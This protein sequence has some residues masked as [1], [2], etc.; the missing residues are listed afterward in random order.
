LEYKILKNKVK[1]STSQSCTAPIK[2]TFYWW[3]SVENSKWSTIEASLK[4]A[5]LNNYEKATL[6]DWSPT[7]HVKPKSNVGAINYLKSS[8]IRK[9]PSTPT[10]I[11]PK[12]HPNPWTSLEHHPPH[13]LPYLKSTTTLHKASFM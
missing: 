10:N 7:P 3:E 13:G 4:Q 8:R 5:I 9:L 1:K 2:L 11:F 12:A 6:R